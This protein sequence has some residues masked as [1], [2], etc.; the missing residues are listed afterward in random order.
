MHWM[1][2]LD[3]LDTVQEEILKEILMVPGPHWVEGYAGTGKTIVLTHAVKKI[4]AQNRQASICFV[5]YTHAL[6]DLV[7]SGLENE[8]IDIF[9]VDSFVSQP[10]KYDWAFIDEVQ[11]IT[12]E[13]I[14][15]IQKLSKRT[16]W[17]GD[18]AQSL[19]HKRVQQN[20][21]PKVLGAK[22]KKLKHIYRLSEKTYGIA[23]TIYPWAKVMRGALVSVVD[24][25][26]VHLIGASTQTQE[27]AWV[28]NKAKIVSTVGRPSAALFP[29]HNG[30]YDFS[31]AV[32][33]F[34]GKPNPPP[35]EKSGRITDYSAF[36]DHFQRNRIPLRFLGS[37][38]G[39]LPESDTKSLC[40]LMTYK[41]AKGL[42]FN[43]VFLPGLNS[44]ISF[45]DGKPLQLSSDEW[46][47]KHFFVGLTRSRRDLF[48]SYHGMPHPY[49]KEMPKEHFVFKKIG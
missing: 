28:W 22:S 34:E 4:R 20:E 23:S 17:A 25:V 15:K 8:N 35:R 26:D 32:A 13:K 48:L 30:I 2:S 9:T 45:E 41:S 16:I 38:N 5:T 47:R 27:V 6:K 33:K 46:Q 36:N 31:C 29:T 39:D 11:D 14:E 19:Y 49:L 18:P 44:D 21:L 40:Y 10:E 1:V 3:E 42:D 12:K 7:A 37:D 24:D 43:S